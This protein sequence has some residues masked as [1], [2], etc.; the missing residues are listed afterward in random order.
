MYL[1]ALG[2]FLVV[3]LLASV[4]APD[5]FVTWLNRILCGLCD[6]FDVLMLIFLC[7]PRITRRSTNVTTVACVLLGVL[8]TTVAIVFPYT[9]ARP[10][11]WCTQHYPATSV[12][13]IYLIQG[14]GCLVIAFLAKSRILGERS[15]RP[16]AF[17]FS[18]W[19]APIYLVTGTILP[20][21]DAN[22]PGN[23]DYG[24]C[25]LA[26]VLIWYFLGLAPVFYLT[27]K[28]DSL[29][30]VEHDLDE[31]LARLAESER[32]MEESAR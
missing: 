8:V 10:C 16:A 5:L 3:Q 17:L 22:Y 19:W 18:L 28:N 15:P 24:F 9:S 6:L 25:L 30:V 12:A 14:A 29:Y 32:L 23:V 4:L 27:V 1:V 11:L 31:E 26:C 20:I 7:L 2:L 13:Y 21:M